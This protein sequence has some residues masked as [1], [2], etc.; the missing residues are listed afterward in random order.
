MFD[1][2]NVGMVTIA[3]QQA[4]AFFFVDL[5][6]RDQECPERVG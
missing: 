4:E 3:K 6:C 5:D 1:D 2:V